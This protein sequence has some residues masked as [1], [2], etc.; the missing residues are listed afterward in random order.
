M[1][2]LNIGWIVPGSKVVGP[3][4]TFTTTFTLAPKTGQALGTVAPGQEL[5]IVSGSMAQGTGPIAPAA[6]DIR[7]KSF[8][9]QLAKEHIGIEG[10]V[11]ATQV[12]NNVWADD[13][14]KII[15]VYSDAMS[16][17]QYRM[18]LKVDGGLWI[19][20]ENPAGVGQLT[21]LGYAGYQN[22]VGGTN[23]LIRSAAAEG[24]NYPHSGTWALTNFDDLT[25][26]LVQ[27]RVPTG[28][29]MFMQGVTLGN[30][31][32]NVLYQA[33]LNTAVN[34]T[35]VADTLFGGGDKGSKLA[36]NIDFKQYGHNTGYNFLFRAM[37]NF[38]NPS[39][40]GVPAY[41]FP[42]RG[43]CMP[44]TQ[45]T[46]PKTGA[47]L[48]NVEY[49]YQGLGAYSRRFVMTKVSGAGED[50]SVTQTLNDWSDTACMSS[51]GLQS[52]AANQ[53]INVY[54]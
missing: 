22:P 5:S 33:N 35:Q 36:M 26:Y 44:L 13:G 30:I 8:Y 46:D 34:Y 6:R 17:L 27:Q 41:G 15:G 37:Y 38:S 18:D 52:F 7:K 47:K 31:I 29:I 11:L 24:L 39:T 16:D 20:Q 28:Y 3:S 23:G 45:I 53:M 10:G 4:P 21:Q 25:T 19:G 14:K 12:W 42:E 50:L 54:H 40:F 51:F 43:L 2:N 32:N 9:L 48:N 1:P 49:V